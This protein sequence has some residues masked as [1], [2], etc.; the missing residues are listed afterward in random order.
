GVRCD[1]GH[2]FDFPV[3]AG[4]DAGL[5]P[6]VQVFL[7]KGRSKAVPGGRTSVSHRFDFVCHD[8]FSFAFSFELSL[9]ISSTAYAVCFCCREHDRMKST[10][11]LAA[12][13]TRIMTVGSAFIAFIH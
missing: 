7:L 12:L 3:E 5:G 13:A 11:S 8:D 2:Q 4:L 1:Q 9:T 6:V 10:A